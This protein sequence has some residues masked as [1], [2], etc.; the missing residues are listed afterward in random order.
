MNNWSPRD[1]G[2]A[3][4]AGALV[5]DQATK[6]FMLYVVGLFY[7]HPGEHVSLLPFFNLVMVWNPGISYG[8]FPAHGALQIT[9]VVLVAL[10]IVGGLGWWLFHTQSRTTAVGLGLAIGG[11]VGNNFIDRPV[12]GRVADFFHFYVGRFDWYVF[13]VADAAI[14]FGMI[15]LL[16]EALK[17]ELYEL[18]ARRKIG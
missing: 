6:L 9:L 4:A 12:Y 2:L 1:L 17:L 10:A 15:A 8:L 18:Q 14:A 13:N 5:L 3:V 7:F 11:A 16:Y